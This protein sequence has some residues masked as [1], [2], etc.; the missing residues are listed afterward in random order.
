MNLCA[1]PSKRIPSFLQLLNRVASQ[2]DTLEALRQQFY[3]LVLQV[4]T[5]A[6]RPEQ[7][8]EKAAKEYVN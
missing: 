5:P 4:L 7:V 3:Q 8:A 2:A 6:E 1:L